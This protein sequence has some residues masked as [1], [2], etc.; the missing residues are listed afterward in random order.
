[1]ADSSF[2]VLTAFS[3]NVSVEP[4]QN[5]QPSKPNLV[6]DSMGFT[7]YQSFEKDMMQEN[8]AVQAD[9]NVNNTTLFNMMAN[10]YAG[11]FLP[12]KQQRQQMNNKYFSAMGLGMR[13]SAD[14]FE[15]EIRESLGPIPET[16]PAKKTFQFIVDALNGRTPFRGVAGAFD[17][18]LQATGKAMDRSAIEKQNRLAYQLK[19]GELAVKQAQD[20]NKII[21]EK[22]A[23][24]YLKSMGYDNEDMTRHMNF[25]QDMLKEIAKTN[26][27]IEK[28][29]IKGA[30]DAA[31]NIKDINSNIRYTDPNT[32]ETLFSTGRMMQTPLGPQMMI[33]SQVE[34]E[35]GTLA[36]VYN[37]PVPDPNFV[38]VGKNPAEEEMINNQN[39]VSQAKV[40]DNVQD[41]AALGGIR[42]DINNIL[43]TAALDINKL[44]FP[45]KIQSVIQTVGFN[46]ES[47]LN[48]LS[49]NSGLSGL[50]GT[51][52][53]NEGKK[54]FNKDYLSYQGSESDNYDNAQFE[55]E[56]TLTDLPSANPFAKKSKTVKASMADI[57][58]ED[59]FIGQGYD[60]SY[61][62][63]KVRENFIV[64][65]LARANKPTGRLNVDDI[66]R[67][68]DAVSIYG[69][70]SPQDVIAALQEVDRK[71]RQAQQGLL[72]AYPEI[73]ATD[74]TFRVESLIDL[75]LDPKDFEQFMTEKQ[76][77]T[78]D[79][80]SMN[81]RVSPDP[82]F[83]SD[84]EVMEIDN[85]F[86]GDSL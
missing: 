2:D 62:E 24:F 63:N 64:Y 61:A 37:K 26:L 23:D 75:G 79:Q 32:G 83:E 55:S 3:P 85:L 39:K 84:G 15:Q 69:A 45:G 81:E 16:G 46:I 17:V 78:T 53:V 72:K 65:G 60:K 40:R 74:P 52:A 76:L 31:N 1:M 12:L 13:V 34:L 73:I 29:K 19:V 56:I 28:T 66:K 50:T 8:Q 51:N 68:S 7:P 77:G 43:E 25:N 57:F 9:Q 6:E 33:P 47:I 21:M 42:T 41:F 82:E 5:K 22:Q 35:D 44:G 70:A 59:W 86:G 18:L 49:K 71:I 10:E 48:E 11:Q 54:L 20:A 67:A 38:L 80:P 30:L 36:L 4:F 27:D 14:D 58:N